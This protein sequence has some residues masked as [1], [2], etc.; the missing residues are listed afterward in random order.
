MTFAFNSLV[1]N[2]LR[3]K[4]E[5]WVWLCASNCVTMIV[6][7]RYVAYGA[8]AGEWDADYGDEV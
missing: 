3:V 1:I 5:E 6:P 8:C 4:Q 7:I 2:S